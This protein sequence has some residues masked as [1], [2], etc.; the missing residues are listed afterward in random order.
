M[1]CA[2]L[3]NRS[4]TTR[5]TSFPSDLG[6]PS[7][8]FMLMSMKGVIGMGRGCKILGSFTFSVLFC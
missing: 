3:L 8:K 2:Y 6:R 5:M 4:T 1:R 7:M